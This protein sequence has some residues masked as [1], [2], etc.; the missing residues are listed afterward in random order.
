MLGVGHIAKSKIPV[1]GIIILFP[2]SDNSMH[3]LAI[4]E[5]ADDEIT[6][7]LGGYTEASVTDFRA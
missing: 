2:L 5:A 1:A 3:H 7:D 6:I 4:R